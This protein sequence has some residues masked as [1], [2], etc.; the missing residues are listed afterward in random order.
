[1]V[2]FA[3]TVQGLTARWPQSIRWLHFNMWETIFIFAPVCPRDSIPWTED[4]WR[5]TASR[6]WSGFRRMMSGL[7]ARA[8]VLLSLI[9]GQGSPVAAQPTMAS[10]L[11]AEGPFWAAAQ[12][13]TDGSG[14]VTFEIEWTW[15]QTSQGGY[16]SFQ[17][18]TIRNN[19]VVEAASRVTRS[20]CVANLT[21]RTNTPSDAALQG[22]PPLCH[23]SA[24]S[25][26]S[27]INFS[28]PGPGEYYLA[29]ARA[30]NFIRSANLKLSYSPG[31]VPI[32]EL[33]DSRS[34]FVGWEE[35][36]GSPLVSVFAAPG[37]LSLSNRGIRELEIRNSM[38]G[39]YADSSQ[40][41]KNLSIAVSGP[42]EFAGASRYWFLGEP[43]GE[44]TFHVD[45]F[46][47]GV[48]F[49]YLHV[50]DFPL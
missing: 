15:N 23:L 1:M 7:S 12:V 40:G 35:F 42:R 34:F 45:G 24:S 38:L 49:V 5:E 44:W 13:T 48:P 25:G 28:L 46:S 31:V 37:G 2:R 22:E 19:A 26:R 21:I 50:L 9:T 29:V 36:Q 8:L 32:R 27:T 33:V 43:S 16:D 10:S 3:R 14:T 47:V 11:S 20:H 41:V 39:I 4:L 6:K 30:G 18:Y 17:K